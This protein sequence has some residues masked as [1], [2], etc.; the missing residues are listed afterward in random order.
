MTRLCALLEQD[1]AACQS[2]LL[3][4]PELYRGLGR[5]PDAQR[6]IDDV[7]HD[8]DPVTRKLIADL[9]DERKTVPVRFRY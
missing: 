7:P 1:V 4:L 6:A 3:Q 2:G 9:I 8:H 5:F